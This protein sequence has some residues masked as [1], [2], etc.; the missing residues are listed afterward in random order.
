[1]LPLGI[2]EYVLM[3]MVFEDQSAAV[4]KLGETLD[5]IDMDMASDTVV[6]DSIKGWRKMFGTWRFQLNHIDEFVDPLKAVLEH[7]GQQGA[8]SGV[9]PASDIAMEMSTSLSIPGNAWDRLGV[10]LSYL[11]K[12]SVSARQRC[13]ATFAALMSTMTIIESEMAIRE[14]AEVSKLTKLAFFFIPLTFVA[15]I[16]GMNLAVSV[17]DDS[18]AFMFA[19][20]AQLL[21]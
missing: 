11:Q 10:R 1:M 5:K 9:T 8:F 21:T 7:L 16:C 13:E 17:P 12:R 18:C 3:T 2:A 14:A 19:R 4:S 15:S 20:H 6:Q